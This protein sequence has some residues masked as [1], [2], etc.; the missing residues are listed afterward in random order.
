V[1]AGV[2]DMGEAIS[3]NAAASIPSDRRRMVARV[4]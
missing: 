2:R 1:T 4:C 3:W